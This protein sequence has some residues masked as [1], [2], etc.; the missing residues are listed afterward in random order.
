MDPLAPK[1][2][3]SKSS[4]KSTTIQVT[5]SDRTAF[6]APPWITGA[7]GNEETMGKR[8]IQTRRDRSW[9]TLTNTN[10]RQFSLI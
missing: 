3:N 1:N 8:L 2:H 6:G 10:R 4:A 9:A 5:P 7:Y